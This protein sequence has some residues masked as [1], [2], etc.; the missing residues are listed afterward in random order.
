MLE[1]IR[2]AIAG[3]YVLLMSA[4]AF[5]ELSGRYARFN[6]QLKAFPYFEDNRTFQACI[7]G[8][9]HACMAYFSVYEY[10]YVFGLLYL[11]MGA[12]G[13]LAVK[14]LRRVLWP[15]TDEQGT[16]S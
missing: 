12:A 11:A 13:A 2:I 3:L 1:N 10:F 14:R 9:A 8:V 4:D 5:M 15:K 6:I 7:W 16:A